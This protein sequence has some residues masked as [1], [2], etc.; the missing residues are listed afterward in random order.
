[1]KSGSGSPPIKKSSVVSSNYSSSSSSNT[2]AGNFEIG[3]FSVSEVPAEIYSKS[4]IGKKS[5][6]FTNSSTSSSS[7][8]TNNNSNTHNKIEPTINNWGEVN[9]KQRNATPTIGDLKSGTTPFNSTNTTTTATAA[10]PIGSPTLNANHQQQPQRQQ[11][12]ESSATTRD[13]QFGGQGM[14]N[15]TNNIN[16]PTSGDTFNPATSGRNNLAPGPSAI[17]SN[18]SQNIGIERYKYIPVLFC[19]KKL[20]Y[21]I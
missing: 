19:L 5:M 18:R 9:I 6:V 15:N 20:I 11:R 8:T 13:N 7:T 14:K 10:V 3:N 21:C 12:H 4:Y 16:G 17:G 1:M 2:N